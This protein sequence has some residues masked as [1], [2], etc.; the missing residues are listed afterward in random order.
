MAS[1]VEPLLAHTLPSLQKLA[2]K[3]LGCGAQE[4]LDIL[5]TLY[6]RGLISYPRTDCGY[7]PTVLYK[8]SRKLVKSLN[9]KVLIH[10]DYKKCFGVDH[11]IQG[12]AWDDEKV[13]T[14]Y[15]IIPLAQSAVHLYGLTPRQVS[16]Y[17]LV[18]ERFLRLFS[19]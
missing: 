14:H 5:T 8:P 2:H 17:F 6:E 11:R 16:V 18:V 15:G 9:G 10:E 4:T 7:L 19:R 13:A 1:T 12:P 3:A